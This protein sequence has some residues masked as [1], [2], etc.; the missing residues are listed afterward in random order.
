MEG[1]QCNVSHVPYQDTMLV[2]NTTFRLRVH[3]SGIPFQES[4]LPPSSTKMPQRY[5]IMW[6][7]QCH[8]PPM[9]GNVLYHLFMVI[10]RMVYCCFTRIK[11]VNN[12]DDESNT[13]E[14]QLNN[15]WT[16][17]HRDQH[18]PHCSQLSAWWT[19]HSTQSAAMARGKFFQ[20]C[21]WLVR[22]WSEKTIRSLD[23]PSG[24]D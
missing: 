4:H 5:H 9:T 24:Y 7:K 11:W 8:K 20:M 13:V 17:C 12:L 6:V 10:W 15:S 16:T 22:T 1:H 19:H 2:A 14:Q 3:L 23:L 21:H 18:V